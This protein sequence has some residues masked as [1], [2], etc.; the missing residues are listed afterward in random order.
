MTT[1]SAS[2][3]TGTTPSTRPPFIAESAAHRAASW[4]P[5][6]AAAA[7]GPAAGVEIVLLG[8][9]LGG[10]A[11][12]PGAVVGYIAATAAVLAAVAIVLG[13]RRL[14]P[15]T[16]RGGGL[17]ALLAGLGLIVAGAIPAV[18]AL[19]IGLLLTGVVGGPLLLTA[20]IVN[21]PKAFRAAMTVGALA[22]A[23]V[24]AVTTEYPGVAVAVAGVV[25]GLAGLLSVAGNPVPPRAVGLGAPDAAVPGEPESFVLGGTEAESFVLGGTA[26]ESF[27]PGRAAPES[28]VPDRAAPESSILGGA[29]TGAEPDTVTGSGPGEWIVRAAAGFAVGAT[30]LP[31]LH[32]L[33]FRWTVL[34]ADQPPYLAVALIPA[35]LVAFLAGARRAAAAPLLVL[36]AGGPVLVA[37]APGPWQ[38]TL[39]IA[40]TVTAAVRALTLRGPDSTKPILALLIPPLAAAV[41]LAL[42]L[43]LRHLWGDGAAL[44]LL[45]LP[46]LAAALSVTRPGA[47]TRP[48]PEP[49]SEGGA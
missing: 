10:R 47:I 40:V 17:L 43:G 31:A 44:T 36:A 30:V 32:L 35:A 45:A 1:P 23:G 19:T 8:K 24:A 15:R 3:G 20:R 48:D 39:G 41:A 28:F 21:E 9:A 33:L 46:V 6:L 38:A 2:T 25:A 34:D 5:L 12:L 29:E 4:L 22:G 13:R 14:P 42:A 26:P 37:T 27:V 18:P 16:G 7:A 49:T 11:G